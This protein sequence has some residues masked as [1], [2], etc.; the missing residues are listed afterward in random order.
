MSWFFLLFLLKLKCFGSFFYNDVVETKLCTYKFALLRVFFFSAL[1][2][3]GFIHCKRSYLLCQNRM[4]GADGN[5]KMFHADVTDCIFSSISM[6]APHVK[7]LSR[8]LKFRNSLKA[9]IREDTVYERY[10]FLC[11][12]LTLFILEDFRFSFHLRNI[13]DQITSSEM[14]I[15]V[16]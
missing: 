13:L 14:L 3:H 11:R 10:S 2:W 6:K 5:W 9:H 15:N 1:E 4:P 12:E 7:N 8:T 16:Y